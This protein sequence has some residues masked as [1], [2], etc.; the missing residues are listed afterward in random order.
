MIALDTFA[1]SL[2]EMRATI[3]FI[4]CEDFRCPM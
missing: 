3:A 4:D 1:P 2:G